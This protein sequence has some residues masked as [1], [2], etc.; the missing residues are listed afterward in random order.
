MPPGGS[1]GVREAEAEHDVHAL[2]DEEDGL[3]IWLRQHVSSSPVMLGL[4][5]ARGPGRERLEGVASASFG[6][7]GHTGD[8]Y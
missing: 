7:A 6:A 2:H 1:G 3:V 5:A 4:E 8:G